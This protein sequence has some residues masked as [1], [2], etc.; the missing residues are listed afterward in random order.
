[1]LAIWAVYRVVVS[2]LHLH[3]AKPEKIS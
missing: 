3:A 1:M 2:L